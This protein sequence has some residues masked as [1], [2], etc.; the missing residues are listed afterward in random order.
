[1]SKN[2]LISGSGIGLRRPHVNDLK[3]H[4]PDSIDFFEIA[5][6]NW[7]RGG[8]KRSETIK[9]FTSNYPVIGHGLSL[10]IGA[11]A[12]LNVDFLKT[13]KGF[14]DEHNIDIYSEHLSYC[15]DGGL[16][17][18]LLPIPFTEEAVRYVAERIQQV[19][20]ILERQIALENISYYVA[21]SP[22]M[23]ELEFVNAVLSEAKCNLLLDVNNIYVN[24]CNHGYN[25][26]AFLKELHADNI[27][28]IHIAGHLK[29]DDVIIDTHGELIID[30]VWQLLEEAYQHFGV[31]PTLLERD[32][33]IPKLSEV[34]D[35]LAIV[36]KI[37]KK[38]V[39]NQ[40]GT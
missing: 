13:L 33:N 24:S 40:Q 9:H 15:G 14:L 28:Y 17:Y 4:C 5:P 36:K 31:I 6:E 38:Y 35:E 22:Q 18:D 39:Q 27:S 10:S 3:V 16:L 37:Q 1:M 25:A 23:S 7:I 20:E 34:L 30:P 19:Q 12:P 32:N 26:S 21:P 29:K 2:Q 8:D 11:P